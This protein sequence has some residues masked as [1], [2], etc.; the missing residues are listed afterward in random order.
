MRPARSLRL[1]IQRSP[2]LPQ[3]LGPPAVGPA[4]WAQDRQE[5]QSLGL[6]PGHLHKEPTL[7]IL[8]TQRTWG[9]PASR[10]PVPQPR[11]CS[12]LPEAALR[13]V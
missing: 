6:S 8:P 1:H 13:P 7:G 5:R 11:S 3:G 4:R 2:E 10:R 12:F 9:R